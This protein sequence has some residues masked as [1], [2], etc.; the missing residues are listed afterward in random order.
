[1]EEEFLSEPVE[2]T[3]QTLDDGQFRFGNLG[4]LITLE[5]KPFQE[6]SRYFVYNHKLTGS[7]KNRQ[8]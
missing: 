2:H 6:P 8:Y 7:S 5:I 4:N 3:D 1:M